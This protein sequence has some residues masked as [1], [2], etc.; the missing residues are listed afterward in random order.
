M[1]RKSTKSKNSELS[2]LKEYSIY[3]LPDNKKE[4]LAPLA[5]KGGNAILLYPDTHA[6]VRGFEK[7]YAHVI[8]HGKWAG[9]A[10]HKK[11]V[12]IG[13]LKIKNQGLL[14][15]ANT[16]NY[17]SII[18]AI[19]KALLAH[20]VISKP[21]F[22]TMLDAGLAET[23]SSF[24]DISD[25]EHLS[26]TDKSHHKLF[27]PKIALK[28]LL[29]L[30]VNYEMK[31]EKKIQSA[32][33]RG[34]NPILEEVDLLLKQDP[35]LALK[36]DHITDLSG[37]KY[38]WSPLEAAHWT[39]NWVLRKMIFKHAQSIPQKAGQLSGEMRAAEQI[40]EWDQQAYNYDL[41]LIRAEQG[42]E[43]RLLTKN[44]PTLIKQYSEEGEDKIF[45]WGD[46]NG[47]WQLT[48]LDGDTK[49]LFAH[50]NFPDTSSKQPTTTPSNQITTGMYDAFKKG[51][52]P[53]HFDLDE[54]VRVA[55]AFH[56][57]YP[58]DA[59]VPEAKRNECNTDGWKIGHAQKKFP[60]WL[61]AVWCSTTIR[62]RRLP[63]AKHLIATPDV[64]RLQLFHQ[65]DFFSPHLGKN[66]SIY[67]G[68][69]GE[70]VMQFAQSYGVF[71]YDDRTMAALSKVITD[72]L[73]K[74][75]Q[76]LPEGSTSTP[77]LI[78]HQKNY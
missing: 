42:E 60:A 16:K 74:F 53:A 29:A 48:E 31:D 77:G 43:F 45:Q 59:S 33:A 73:G 11:E 35:T 55:H 3:L 49:K 27:K 52:T 68:A 26:Q 25:L 65:A 54:F 63:D 5:V 21:D 15:Q 17:S 4:T 72:E 78:R 19:E 8:K 22:K 6:A 38:Y 58:F 2:L 66:F 18:G 40:R 24:L 36:R 14:T 62:F 28:K 23:V 47:E 56:K 1:F 67:K 7:Y 44:I 30:I 46:V 13:D 12:P 37:R 50:L 34:I 10:A 64:C 75:K 57:K 61:A 69:R 39:G 76:L 20:K 41:F 70:C 32:I 51:H 9:G 71:S